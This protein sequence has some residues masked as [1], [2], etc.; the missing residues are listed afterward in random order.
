MQKNCNMVG[1]FIKKALISIFF[2]SFPSNAVTLE[3][4]MNMP[5]FVAL[6][7]A[8]GNVNRAMR[9]AAENPMDDSRRINV[10][11]AIAALPPAIIGLADVFKANK[12]HKPDYPY[13]M[14]LL[15]GFVDVNAADNYKKFLKDP[16]PEYIPKVGE[17][18]PVQF[19][20]STPSTKPIGAF[21]N[22]ISKQE[23]PQNYEPADVT[24]YVYD[25][26]AP[27]TKKE[28]A[29]SETVRKTNEKLESIENNNN[30]SDKRDE[31]SVIASTFERERTNLLSII[32]VK[33]EKST[34]L[35]EDFFRKIASKEKKKYKIRAK[36][37][38]WKITPLINII[39]LL[40]IKEAH[41]EE[42]GGGS[43]CPYCQASG[44]GEG[45][46]GDGGG[47][48]VA[49]ILYGIAAIIS[50]IVP[51]VVAGIQAE[52]DR[53]IAKMNSLTQIAMT[54]M[55]S[56]T[57]KYM[58]NRQTE[59]AMFQAETAQEIAEKN[60]NAVT[61]RLA[62]QLAELNEARKEQTALN[63]K[64]LEIE[65]SYNKER[66]EIA[67]KQ[68]DDAARLQRHMLN[69]QISQAGLSSS[70]GIST[71]QNSGP[72]IPK[73]TTVS[74]MSGNSQSTSSNNSTLNLS[75]NGNVRTP[76]SSL[77]TSNAQNIPASIAP[78]GI[79]TSTQSDISNTKKTNSKRSVRNTLVSRITSSTPNVEQSLNISYPRSNT[80]KQLS[81]RI[82]IKNSISQ[83]K[84]IIRG[85]ASYIGKELYNILMA[86]KV[87]YGSSRGVK[88]R[89]E[90]KSDIAK[91]I[92]ETKSSENN[93][94][95]PRSKI[96]RESNKKS[97]IS[98]FGE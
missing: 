37:K 24:S 61:Q 10:R 28:K 22:I 9:D 54:K 95:R 60:N 80:M 14:G 45:E 51:A 64:R 88:N 58:T 47:A 81:N 65:D 67:L 40:A 96:S 39:N 56:D 70:G 20:N 27:K 86:Y 18:F 72:G 68:A 91:F 66:I 89:I 71:V 42:G 13:V 34:A 85:S 76:S 98:N 16:K 50:S 1:N 90:K 2:I 93:F 32:R 25:E 35:D 59:I 26:S 19:L 74:S 53:D 94:F 3:G 48:D 57:S 62:M 55:T 43:N 5:E 11:K 33:N 21:K 36:P 41:G 63:E 75:T 30:S 79:V 17:N 78:K 7:I 12:L 29:L 31:N 44:G 84:K 69:A 46:G 6:A 15:G 38:Y 49:G 83:K 52:A 8:I 92:E 73:T 97:H 87:I 82:Q 23:I 77:L 4:L